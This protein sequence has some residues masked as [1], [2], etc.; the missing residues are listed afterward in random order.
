MPS[1]KQTEVGV[2]GIKGRRKTPNSRGHPKYVGVRQRPSGRWVAEI[3]DSLQKVRLWLG[4]FDTAEDAAQAYDQA[5]RT[6]RGANART[7][8]ELPN[9]VNV[10]PCLAE[11]AEPF[12]FEEACGMEGTGEGGLLGALKAKLYD[13]TTTSHA[14]TSNT[15]SMCL[16]NT[17]KR[18]TPPMVAVAAVPSPPKQQ[19]SNEPVSTDHC[20]PADQDQNHGIDLVSPNQYDGDGDGLQGCYEP[21]LLPT[22]VPWCTEIPWLAIPN[23]NNIH[24]SNVLF[25]TSVMDSLWSVSAAEANTSSQL[26]GVGGWPMGQQ[27]DFGWDGGGQTITNTNTN[28]NSVAASWDPFAYVNSVL[29]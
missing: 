20:M 6:L 12:S 1:F 3:K 11:N 23:I 22:S 28:S 10:V 13:S 14:K 4:T 2:G 27:S 8:F 24:S 19:A 16:T 26:G 17:R 29:G 21:S 7:N 5:A 9:N 15:S 18:K 25:D